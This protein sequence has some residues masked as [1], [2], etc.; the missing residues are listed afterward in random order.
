MAL[1]NYRA[2]R[3]KPSSSASAVEPLEPRLLLSGGVGISTLPGDLNADGRV[4]ASDISVLE[5]V[6]AGTSSGI[7]GTDINE[8][9]ILDSNDLVLLQDFVSA[10]TSLPSVHEVDTYVVLNDGWDGPGQ[11]SASLRYWFE[12][13]SSDLTQAQQRNAIISALNEWATYANI[14]WSEAQG[15]DE[16][17]SIDF[18]FASND[19]QGG[20]LAFAYYPPPS[21]PEPRAGDICFDDDDTWTVDGSGTDLF[22]VALHELGHSLGLAH[23]SDSDAVMYAYYSGQVTG[24][25]QDD[26]SG[27]QSIYGND[28]EIWATGWDD[29][30]GDGDGFPE[31]GENIEC[32]V[33]LKNTSD[34]TIANVRGWLSTSWGNVDITDNEVYYGDISAGDYEGGGSH[35]DMFLDFASTWSKLPF[36]L[37]VNYM[38]EGTEYWKNLS[39]EKTFHEDGDLAPEIVVDHIVWDD[40]AHGDGDGVL[41]SGEEADMYLS[42]RNVGNARAEHVDVMVQDPDEFEIYLDWERYPDLHDGAA[43]VQAINGGHFHVRDVP[44]SMS[45]AAYTDVTVRYGEA[46]NLFYTIEDVE[47]PVVATPY[48]RAE[49]TENSDPQLEFGVVSPGIPVTRQLRLTNYGTAPLTISQ[50][51]EGYADTTITGFAPGTVLPPGAAQEVTVSIDTSGMNATITRDIVVQSNGHDGWPGAGSTQALRLAGTVTEESGGSWEEVFSFNASGL[52]RGMDIGDT[53]GDGHREII[54]LGDWDDP[55]IKVFERIGDNQ[56]AER[57]SHVLSTSGSLQEGTDLLRVADVNG[58][59]K[60][61][62]VCGVYS[63]GASGGRLFLIQSSSNNAWSVTWSA[64]TNGAL[65]ELIT[66]DADGDGRTEI[67]YSA[68]SYSDSQHGHLYVLENRGGTSFAQILDIR[69]DE[70]DG[71]AY[72][73]F[74]GMAVGDS[75]RDGRPELVFTAGNRTGGWDTNEAQFFIYEST[76]DNGFAQRYAGLSYDV[77]GVEPWYFARTAIGDPDGDGLGEIIIAEDYPDRLFIIEST[78]DNSWA[79]SPANWEYSA[80]FSRDPWVVLLEDIDDDPEEE[81]LLGFVNNPSVVI[82]DGF[83]TDSYVQTWESEDPYYYACALAVDCTDA[84][85][86][87]RIL[88]GSE[89][90]SS[91]APDVAAYGEV[92]TQDVAISEAGFAAAPD[93]PVEGVPVTLSARVWNTQSAAVENIVV[94]FFDGDPTSGGTQIGAD[95][96]IASIPGTSSEIAQVIWNP[97][98]SGEYECHVVVDPDDA[99]DEGDDTNNSATRT[100]V[101]ADDD[102]SGPAIVNVLVEDEQGDADGVVGA[103]EQAEISWDVT[104]SSGVA[105]VSLWVDLDQDGLGEVGSRDPDDGVIWTGS[106]V[107]VL[108]PLVAGYYEFAIDAEDSDNSPAASSYVGSFLVVNAEEITVSHNGVPLVDGQLEAVG[109]GTAMY[110]ESAVSKLL[111]IRNDGEQELVIGSIVAPSGFTV[112]GPPVNI[113]Q[114][115]EATY[116]TVS[117]QT[118]TVGSQSGD[119]RIASSDGP[120]SPDGMDEGVFT[121]PVSGTVRV[122]GDANGDGTVT[123]ADYTIWADH[124]RQTN[125]TWHMGDFDGSGEVTDADYTIWADNYGAAASSLS[126]AQAMAPST[127]EP[128]PQPPVSASAPVELPLANRRSPKRRPVLASSRIRQMGPFRR[129]SD[130]LTHPGDYTLRDD[131]LWA[132]E[133]SDEVDLL[134]I[135]SVPELV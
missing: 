75:D 68:Y 107:A 27:I 131:G 61:D 124:Y 20:T 30:D 90:G 129:P 96:V 35:F 40:S 69:K 121:F 112:A 56:Y 18:S 38:K 43:A 49:W 14:T 78:A 91:V 19:G 51:A 25:A 74:G 33:Y 65:Y 133:E 110:G 62:I 128:E 11:G 97:A 100:V 28:L 98:A 21:N 53:D 17:S 48:L 15:P 106:Y 59:G 63:D 83:G 120:R 114:P 9:G 89:S 102:V 44:I 86:K 46:E 125:A 42:L 92:A 1:R 104:D 31:A 80:S 2:G 101:V 22:S 50:V 72:K 79:L 77:D 76:G 12:S 105:T 60:D 10:G 4:D 37:H 123:D 52:L 70:S 39:F 24:L 34:S 85:G 108:G 58:D 118:D 45:G 113:L 66:G 16:N 127:A 5:G 111:N 99:L 119:I 29:P 117:L 41:E 64:T 23:S 54:T 32:S 130:V 132:D 87:P 6:L 36:T 81:I 8:D 55:E 122:P 93:S 84:S 126:A 47:I 3:D 94:R 116:I 7:A 88:V 67:I 109:F 26:I 135:L 115:G 71:D 95:Q 13:Y 57:W 134:A 82:I 73:S 103:D